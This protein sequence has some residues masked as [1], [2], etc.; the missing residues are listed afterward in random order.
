VAHYEVFLFIGNTLS[1]SVFH[2]KNC[3]CGNR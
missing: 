1:Y 3:E 2:T